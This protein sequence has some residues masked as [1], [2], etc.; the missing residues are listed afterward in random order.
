MKRKKKPKFILGIYNHC[1]RWCERCHLTAHCRLFADQKKMEREFEEREKREKAANETAQDLLNLKFWGELKEGFDTSLTKLLKE[2]ETAGADPFGASDDDNFEF[3]DDDAAES[4][5]PKRIR[6]QLKINIDAEG[7]SAAAD[8]F[9]NVNFE[10]FM[11]SGPAN[12]DKLDEAGRDIDDALDVISWYLH[13][14]YVKLMRACKVD[15]DEGELEDAGEITREFEIEDA[16]LSARLALLGITR[17]MHAWVRVRE[18]HP[19]HGSAIVDLLLR[20]NVLRNDIEEKF[21]DAEKAKLW[22]DV[23]APK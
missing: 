14:I 23:K 1:D 13:F 10:K 20:L 11:T 6:P 2:A 9:L 12:R 3:D 22:I 17:S 21:P 8:K 18:R 7:Y 5:K 16:N 4:W 15:V 19:E